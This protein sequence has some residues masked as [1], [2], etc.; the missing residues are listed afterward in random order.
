MLTKVEGDWTLTVYD[1][2]TQQW[3]RGPPPYSSLVIERVIALKSRRKK[4]CVV[5]RRS[6]P[7]SKYPKKLAGPFD[8][9]EGAKVALI[10]IQGNQ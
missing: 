2:G 10:M 9:L 6:D 8:T 7:T 1:D 3:H 5:D 4:W